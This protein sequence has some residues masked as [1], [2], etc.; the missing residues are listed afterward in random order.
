MTDALPLVFSM[1]LT[2]QFFPGVDSRFFF[3]YSRKQP[4]LLSTHIYPLFL[5]TVI[6]LLFKFRQD[7]PVLYVPLGWRTA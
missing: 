2:D 6:G 1:T 5:S 7:V 3:C 4:R